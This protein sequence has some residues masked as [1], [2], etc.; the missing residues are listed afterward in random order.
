MIV[1]FVIIII[2]ILFVNKKI[3]DSKS[4]SKYSVQI[5]MATVAIAATIPMLFNN[6]AGNQAFNYIAAGIGIFSAIAILYETFIT[7]AD[8]KQ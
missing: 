4:K 6:N 1:L 3:A 7:K 8:D 5:A 2:L